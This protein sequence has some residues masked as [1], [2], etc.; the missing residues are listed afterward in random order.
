[1]RKEWLAMCAVLLLVAQTPGVLARQ[2]GVPAGPLDGVWQVVEATVDGKKNPNPQPGMYVFAGSH[3]SIVQ[4]TA[5]AARVPNPSP[6]TSADFEALCGNDVFVASAGTYEVSGQ[7]VTFRAI[8]A[9]NPGG[10]MPGSFTTRTY[11]LSPDKAA[12]WLRTTATHLG[13]PVR[14]TEFALKR[15]R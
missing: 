10:M 8:V 5:P 12:L 4:V 1:M 2:R 11:R 9:K 15:L 3:F 14:D 6:K 7:E 13:P